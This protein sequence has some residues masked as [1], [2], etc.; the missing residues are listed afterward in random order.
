MAEQWYEVKDGDPRAVALYRRHYSCKGVNHGVPIDY[1]RYGF[2][3]I[4][5]SMILLTPDCS[6][7]FGWLK[8]KIRDDEQ[9]GVNCFVFRNERKENK[10]SEL[11]KLAD[12]MAWDKWGCERLF[13][14][15][16]PKEVRTGKSNPGKCFKKAGWRECGYSK[17]G[18]LI[19]EILPKGESHD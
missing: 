4:G 12:G 10:S 2:S 1:V 15:V 13:T 14:F 9:I 8:Q 3:G 19:L 6:A 11:I 16:D 17:G 18:L 7:L 5:E